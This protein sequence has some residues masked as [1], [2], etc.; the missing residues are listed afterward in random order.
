MD[1]SFIENYLF[2]T[3]E[4]KTFKLKDFDFISNYISKYPNKNKVLSKD[5]VTNFWTLRDINALKRN[6][7]FVE[8]PSSNTIAVTKDKLAYYCYVDIFKRK[9]NHIPYYFGNSDVII[10]KENFSL[11]KNIFIN[12]SLNHYSFLKNINNQN[13]NNNSSVVIDDYFKKLLGEHY[14]D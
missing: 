14:V 7:T 13:S 3:K 8:K 5:I 9:I 12:E 4:E 1:Y 2:K 6:K 10:D 11:I